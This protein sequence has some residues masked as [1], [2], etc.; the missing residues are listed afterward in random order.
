MAR[1]IRP[2]RC[3]LF[4]AWLQCQ[5]G[6]EERT[7]VVMEV[8]EVT[9]V[10]GARMEGE[11]AIVGGVVVGLKAIMVV[12]TIRSLITHLVPL[13]VDKLT[14]NSTVIVR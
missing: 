2:S 7:K 14:G 8:E 5:T 3:Q 4:Q 12:E 10:A 11:A 13:T 9:R 6:M 1:M